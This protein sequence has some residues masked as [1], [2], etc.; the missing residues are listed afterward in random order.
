M[1]RMMPAVP[2]IVMTWLRRFS[3]SRCRVVITTYETGFGLARRSSA[4]FGISHGLVL[5][6]DLLR[7][8]LIPADA[9]RVLLSKRHV[10]R[11]GASLGLD[12]THF[13]RRK[14]ERLQL[15]GTG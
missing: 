1:E 13:K 4:H 14:R 7:S 9:G 2:A 10:C 5:R 12:F 8:F 15:N 6:D 11:A 3:N